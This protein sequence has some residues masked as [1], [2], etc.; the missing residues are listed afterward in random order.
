MLL[1]ADDGELHLSLQ[2]RSVIV[3]AFL[4]GV[5]CGMFVSGLVLALVA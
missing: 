4:F 2:T 3:R 5:C 1:K